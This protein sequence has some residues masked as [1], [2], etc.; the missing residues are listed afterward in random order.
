[1][2]LSLWGCTGRASALSQWG[3]PETKRWRRSS[4]VSFAKK[5]MALSR[6]LHHCAA[7]YSIRNTVTAA[8]PKTHAWVRP[9]CPWPAGTATHR[10]AIASLTGRGGVCSPADPSRGVGG[11]VLRTL[12]ALMLGPVWI[13]K[14]GIFWLE[15]FPSRKK[16]PAPYSIWPCDDHPNMILEFVVKIRKPFWMCYH[17]IASLV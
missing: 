6:T 3:A 9:S 11:P 1:M 10:R 4:C 7:G 2:S 16:T 14:S 17:S 13:S 8:C 5:T 12:E 15:T